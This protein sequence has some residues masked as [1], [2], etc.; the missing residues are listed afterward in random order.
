[1]QKHKTL[2]GDTQKAMGDFLPH[3]EYDRRSPD[4][5]DGSGEFPLVASAVSSS[6]PLR[7]LGQSELLYAPL[8]H[9]QDNTPAH[10]QTS[11]LEA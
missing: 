8:R 1:M 5:G 9:L 4:E 6:L 3:Q 2:F 11:W 7:V 10:G